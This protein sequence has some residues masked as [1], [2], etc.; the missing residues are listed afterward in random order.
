MYKPVT[1]VYFSNSTHKTD[2][3][4]KLILPSHK[5]QENPFKVLKYLSWRRSRQNPSY[6][7]KRNQGF[8]TSFAASS[9]LNLEKFL[10]IKIRFYCRFLLSLLDFGKQGL[11]LLIFIFKVW[12]IN[13][14]HTFML[15]QL[16]TEMKI[17]CTTII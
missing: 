14:I 11:H 10:I 16:R 6:Y 12:F 7:L 5:A 17:F 2:G 4:R 3:N 1:K 15:L 8:I 9:H 13:N